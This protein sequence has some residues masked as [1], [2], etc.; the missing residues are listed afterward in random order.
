MIILI[1]LLRLCEMEQSESGRENMRLQTMKGRS[2]E[3][4][5]S[6]LTLDRDKYFVE[7]PVYPEKQYLPMCTA[8][9]LSKAQQVSR[10]LPSA[11]NPHKASNSNNRRMN[12][13]CLTVPVTE[14]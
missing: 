12:I 13:L 9:D 11:D 1:T 5:V 10:C 8:C 4:K 3:A 7:C 6:S 2:T 14:F